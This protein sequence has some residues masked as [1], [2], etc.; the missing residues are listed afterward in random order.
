MP[1]KKRRAGRSKAVPEED[2]ASEN[3]KEGVADANVFAVE[4]MQSGIDS[5]GS[6]SDSSS[7]D[8]DSDSGDE[9]EEQPLFIPSSSFDGPKAG[10]MF[11]N[12]DDGLGY[13]LDAESKA[14]GAAPKVQKE[15]AAG[16]RKSSGRDLK[17][18]LPTRDEMQ[19]LRQ[20]TEKWI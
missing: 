20:A 8:S 6:S 3:L 18:S 2:H 17:Y 1:R 15:G 11:K 16:A 9:G 4:K 13:Y 14:N 12:D 10:Y 7:S 19:Q 5:E